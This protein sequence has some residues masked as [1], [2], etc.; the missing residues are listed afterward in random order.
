MNNKIAKY[1]SVAVFTL[2]ASA[3]NFSFTTAS[4]SSLKTA[5][6]KA[7]TQETTAFKGGESLHAKAVVSNAGKVSV[8]FYLLADEVPG[9]KKGD[10]V[11]GSEV[12]VDLPSS[13]TAD[14]DVTFPPT[15]SGKYSVVADLLN[16]SGEKTESKSVNFTLE[17][18]AAAPAQGGAADDD[19]KDDSKDKEGGAVG[20]KAEGK[21]SD[22]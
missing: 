7:G 21:G 19:N 5:S 1:C 2:A 3:C 6:D 4:I 22:K 16:E 10:V 17:A 20:E 11:P 13:G 8:K 15:W 9:A 18:A 14:F 12:K